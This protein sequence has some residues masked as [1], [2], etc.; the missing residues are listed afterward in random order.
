MT[1]SKHWDWIQP[2]VGSLA[3]CPNLASPQELNEE[4]ILKN[5][6]RL[7]VECFIFSQSIPS[8]VCG[9]TI[10]VKAV[11]LDLHLLSCLASSFAFFCLRTRR[12]RRSSTVGKCVKKYWKYYNTIGRFLRDKPNRYSTPA[13]FLQQFLPLKHFNVCQDT[14]GGFRSNSHIAN[15]QVKGKCRR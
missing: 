14:T 3:R 11:I 6:S 12:L 9:C 5:N 1:Q 4:F 8:S 13:F 15:S 2:V 10:P 7:H